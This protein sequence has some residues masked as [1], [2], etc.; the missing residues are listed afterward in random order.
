MLIYLL[1]DNKDPIRQSLLNMR[2]FAYALALLPAVAFAAPA[3]SAA[4]VS[5]Q[6]GGDLACKASVSLPWDPIS[7]HTSIGF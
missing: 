1:Q 4:Q 2:F 7:V 5:C 6:L 3:E